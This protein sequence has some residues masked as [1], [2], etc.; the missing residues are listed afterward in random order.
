MKQEDLIEKYIQNRLSSEE[1]LTFDDLLKNN[2]DFKE[3]VALHTNLK[4]AI[5]NVDDFNFRNL[6]SDLESKAKNHTQKR[7][8]V[9]WLAAASIVLFLGLTYFLTIDNKATGNELFAS[10][11]KPYRNVVHPIV[12]GNDQQDKKAL[13]FIAYEKGEYE[14]AIT[15]FSNLYTTTKEPYYL[16]YK[17]N[18]LLKL[19]RTN[20]AIP[21]LLS[22]LK[23]K[24]TLT[25]KTNWY[26]AL[27]YLKLEDKLKAKKLLEEV[28]T[29]GSY[30]AKEAKELL[31]EFD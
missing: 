8:Y 23:T 18:S 21:L 3:K 10:Y 26:L 27:A 22:H 24:D 7:S 28:I 14:T 16:F 2:D 30:K 5:G 9:K 6:I 13:A 19:E 15:L 4:K 31:K 17:A 25:E 20:E 11:F 1:K 29:K 12:R